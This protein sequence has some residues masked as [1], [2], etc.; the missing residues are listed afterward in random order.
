MNDETK[1]NATYRHILA[2]AHKLETIQ[3]NLES[4]IDLFSV[5]TVKLSSKLNS[6]CMKLLFECDFKLDYYRKS[7]ELLWRR[8]YYDIYRFQKTKRQKIKRQDE[9]LIESHFVSGIG[10]YSTFI[11]K[12]RSHYNINDV[13]GLVLPFDLSLG[14]VDNFAPDNRLNDDLCKSLSPTKTS[15]KSSIGIDIAEQDPAKIWARLA[16]YRS[17]VYMGDLARYL[18]EINQHDYRRLAYDFYLS[19]SRNQPDYGLPFN[20]LATLAGS[21]NNNLDAVCNYMRCCLKQKPFERAEGNM[22][23]LFEINKKFY[24]EF[25]KTRSIMSVSEV[26]SSKEP[27]LAAEAMVHFVT[28]SFINLTSDLWSAI[29]DNS[30][31]SSLIKLIAEETRAFFECLREALD[32][33]PIIPLA[34]H[35]T[36]IRDFEPISDG[37]HSNEKPKYITPSIMYEFCSVSMMLIAKYQKNQ[38]T[39]EGISRKGYNEIADLVYALALNLLYYSTSKCQKMIIL[40]LQ[41][42]R[43]N[44]M[45][46]VC[47]DLSNIDDRSNTWTKQSA[48]NINSGATV[49]GRKSLSRLRQ[50]EAASN[51]LDRYKV[52][53]TQN[54][55]SDMSELEETAL[56]TIDALEISSDMSEEADHQASDLIDLGSSSCDDETASVATNSINGPSLRSLTCLSSLSRAVLRP[57]RS[58]NY[59]LQ[60]RSNH[61]YGS[62]N[63]LPVQDLVTGDI[64]ER[65]D[66]KAFNS[67]R[68]LFDCDSAARQGSRDR[69]SPVSSSDNTRVSGQTLQE[70][71]QVYAFVYNQSYLPTI[72]VF[73][74]WLLS[75]GHIIGMNLSSFHGFS[76]ELESLGSLLDDLKKVAESKDIGC[77]QD[78]ANAMDT[79]GSTITSVDE[80][81]LLQSHCFKGPTWKQKYPLTCDYPLIHLEPIQATH[82]MNINFDSR[83][84]LTDSE[85]GFVSIQCVKAFSHAL[86]IFLNNKD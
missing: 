2:S 24:G 75:N 6:D 47:P 86:G 74:D 60:S 49:T 53:I 28:V 64:C 83:R 52:T 29:S 35:Q 18:L 40:K 27:R 23:A 5:P 17:L 61:L 43:L 45:E 58:Q 19:A 34:Q 9:L 36:I 30:V 66:Q 33:E 59:E 21:Q 31:D 26:F 15:S 14:P 20:Q 46:Q 76:K 41:E 3:C 65:L 11:V 54:D 22:L 56:S 8:I 50:R 85:S 79:S 67:S 1:R 51:Y 71:N 57:T 4:V 84:E 80:D 7:E 25:E 68:S 62:T 16:I 78:T 55:D 48:N 70:I 39:K 10:F 44:P 82:E 32:L 12:L 63:S 13:K 77:V 42:L 37:S 69:L 81:N 72:K 73:C 38:S